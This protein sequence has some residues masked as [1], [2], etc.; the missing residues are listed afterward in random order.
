MLFLGSLI[1]STKFVNMKKLFALFLVFTS[2]AF[3]RLPAQTAERIHQIALPKKK[4]SEQDKDIHRY[5]YREKQHILSSANKQ[6]LDSVIQ[7]G[8]NK[9]IFE[10][11]PSGYLVRITDQEKNP[12]TRNWETYSKQEFTT[13]SAGQITEVIEY[14]WISA[15]SNW[16]PVDR[17]IW[18]YD[19]SS[20]LIR[21][22][23]Y[24]R[25][26]MGWVAYDKDEYTYDANGNETEYNDY[27]WDTDSSDWMLWYQVKSTFNAKNLIIEENVNQKFVR[28]TFLRPWSK[29]YFSYVND[30]LDEKV[31][32]SYSDDDMD[33]V[34]Y[35]REKYT[36]TGVNNTGRSGYYWDAVDELWTETDRAVFTYD[37]KNNLIGSVESEYDTDLMEWVNTYKEQM[38]FNN[39]Y[40][41]DE[42][43]VPYQDFEWKY[44]IT[45]I[46][47]FY[48]D[49]NTWTPS[50]DVQLF[51]SAFSDLS[52]A[53]NQ[54]IS[55]LKLYP[56]PACDLL[57]VE[58]QDNYTGGNLHFF[59]LK[60]RMV[61]SVELMMNVPINMT[62]L[63]PGM[64]LYELVSP[65][66]I[67]RGKIIKK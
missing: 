24:E 48:W 2:V 64:Y 50:Y 61:Y 54:G 8:E 5:G 53:R 4:M 22:T 15:S 49:N 25:D 20:N 11:N 33:W 18:E 31:E 13:N 16:I 3:T 42:L 67:Y 37:N 34:N 56:N 62:E 21:L 55:H 36:Y 32:L 46:S 29:T 43:V 19:G 10:Y 23:S 45:S 17:E 57:H 65:G 51:Y 52:S 63:D 35:R 40:S 66:Q 39:D 6:K 60:G 59:D 9:S 1:L 58:M 26:G 38:T 30:L 12:F 27:D 14:D 7:S 47:G 28:E 41:K 44:M